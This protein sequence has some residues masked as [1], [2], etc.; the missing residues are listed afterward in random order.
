MR[1]HCKLFLLWIY[2]WSYNNLLRLIISYYNRISKFLIRSLLIFIIKGFQTIV[3]IF[4]VISIKLRPICPP[5]FFRCLSNTGTFTELWTT[6]FIESTGV[7][8]SDSISHNRVHVLSIPVCYSLAV[9]IEPA[10]SRW[11]S[12]EIFGNLTTINISFNLE[13]HVF[14]YPWG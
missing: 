4:M 10:T 13:V 9:R 5:A 6:F 2:T 12:F 8:C 14:R 11:L 3:F 7:A 1:Y